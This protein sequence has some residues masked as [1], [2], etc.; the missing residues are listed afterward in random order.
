MVRFPNKGI[1]P[2]ISRMF[3]IWRGAFRAFVFLV[4]FVIF[5]ALIVTLEAADSHSIIFT[6]QKINFQLCC[7]ITFD[8]KL[9][10]VHVQKSLSVRS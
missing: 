5:A 3:F 2:D 7:R 6:Y 9:L 4:V 8:K 1:A 10:S